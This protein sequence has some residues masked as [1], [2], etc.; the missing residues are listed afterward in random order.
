MLTATVSQ[1][2]AASPIEPDAAVVERVLAGDGAAFRTL[3]ERYAPAVL[4]F[5]AS[6]VEDH[7][8]AEDALQEAF[9]RAFAALPTYDARRAF[10]PWVAT[11]AE[12]VA[13]DELRRRRPRKG[14]GYGPKEAAGADPSRIASRLEREA[15][16]RAALTAL[17][18]EPRRVLLLR[19]ERGLTQ[20]ETS[21]ELGCSVRTVQTREQE[22]L[23]TVLRLLEERR[24][25]HSK[26]VRP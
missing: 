21:I 6:R 20:R 5:L 1:T 14:R 19:Y 25:A 17:G 18:P 7:A 2:D 10:G 11:I 3:Y 22:A 13:N 12:N 26:E 15:V 9:C 24:A 23:D 16:L 8:L 4:G